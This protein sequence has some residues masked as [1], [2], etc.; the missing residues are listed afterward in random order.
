MEQRGRL[1]A[2][3]VSALRYAGFSDG[4]VTEIISAVVLNIYRSYFNLIARPEIDF[5]L[6]ATGYSA[7]AQRRA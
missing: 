6:V 4:E 2:S 7:A 1:P 5:P 3:E